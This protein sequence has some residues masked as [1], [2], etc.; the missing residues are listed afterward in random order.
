MIR[1]G[2]AGL[3]FMGMVHYLS[4]QKLRGVKVAAICEMNKKRLTGD[5]RDIKGNFGPAGKKMDLSG[6]ETTTSLDDMLANP[7]IDMV[8]IT[9]PPSLHA[10]MACRAMK[11]GKHVFCEKP[12]AV[13]VPGVR[14]VLETC[15]RAKEKGLSVVSGLCYR[16]NPGF[17]EGVT[18]DP[19]VNW[20]NCG[21]C[22]GFELSE[23]A[24]NAQRNVARA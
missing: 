2:I 17:K 16:E 18:G 10:D 13:D 7:D 24:S 22:G 11:A 9:L 15:Q 8:D 12:V 21:R 3:G 1:V 6:I 14:E 19:P 4:Y 5:W 23:I 20:G